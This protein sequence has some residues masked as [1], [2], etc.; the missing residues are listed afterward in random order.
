[1]RGWVLAMPID[2]GELVHGERLSLWPRPP[3]DRIAGD[4]LDGAGD[5]PLSAGG[6]GNASVTVRLVRLEPP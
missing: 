2:Y 5:A 4:T 3:A 1:M 6:I